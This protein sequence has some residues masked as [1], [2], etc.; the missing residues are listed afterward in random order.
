M[1]VFVHAALLLTAKHKAFGRQQGV[2]HS[3][4][5][6]AELDPEN[7]SGSDGGCGGPA[8]DVDGINLP[9]MERLAGCG[10]VQEISIRLKDPGDCNFTELGL[11]VDQFLIPRFD[12]YVACEPYL[13]RDK[14]SKTPVLLKRH[15]DSR[16]QKI[17]KALHAHQFPATCRG[18]KI[19]AAAEN[20]RFIGSLFTSAWRVLEL[21]LLKQN[22]PIYAH[23]HHED[24]VSNPAGKSLF[25]SYCKISVLHVPLC[26]S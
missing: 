16:I 6:A 1:L 24:W 21:I 20:H 11:A 19:A 2:R 3:L 22:T 13:W 8:A 14:P 5:D 9:E 17:A 12:W 7:L 25:Q 4:I 26:N 15:A 18:K 10:D 23:F